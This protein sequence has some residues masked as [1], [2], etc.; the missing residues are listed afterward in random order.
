[1]ADEPLSPAGVARRDAILAASL[2]A[3]ARHRSNRR[4]TRGLIVLI[5]LMIGVAFPWERFVRPEPIMR[6]PVGT[7]TRVVPSL[8]ERFVLRD[9][10]RV[11]TVA[12]DAELLDAL[13][14]GGKPAGLTYRDGHATVVTFP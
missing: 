14:A 11:A 4:A 2:R 1:M 6:G 10:P 5:P 13:S 8:E 9:P 12:T 3:A 7:T